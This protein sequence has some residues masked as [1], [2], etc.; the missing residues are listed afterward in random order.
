MRAYNSLHDEKVFGMGSIEEQKAEIAAFLGNTMHESDMFLA[1]RE[2]LPCGDS[3][4]VDGKLYRKPCDS[5]SFDWSTRTPAKLGRK[6][7]ATRPG[8]ARAVLSA[9]LNTGLKSS[10]MLLRKQS[11]YRGCIFRSLGRIY[12]CDRLVFGRGAIQLSWNYNYI[13]ASVALTGNANTFCDDPDLVASNPKYAWGAGIWFWMESPKAFQ[14]K[15]TETM[16]SHT[17]ALAGDFGATVYNITG[18]RVSAFCRRLS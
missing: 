5:G 7:A 13:K 3:K 6:F 16:T 9:V 17:A 10:R 15:P 18:A 11:N 8:N 2:Y 4:V 12:S 1:P 14:Q